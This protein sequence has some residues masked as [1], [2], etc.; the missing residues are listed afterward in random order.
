MNI[1]EY[2]QLSAYARYDGIYLAVL[3]TASFA[4]LIFTPTYPIA[5][6]PCMLLAVATPFFVSYRLWKFRK[7]GRDNTISFGRALTYCLR[8]FFNAAFFFAAIQWAYMRFV[9]NGQIGQLLQGAL[10]NPEAMVMMKQA[11]YS[12]GLMKEAVAT[13]NDMTPFTFATTYFIN[14]ILIGAVLSLPIAAAMK[15]GDKN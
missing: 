5:S 10:D 6:M 9:D 2:R 8:V 12:E 14:N 7:E 15:R 11:G 13:F 4:C 3:W 1:E